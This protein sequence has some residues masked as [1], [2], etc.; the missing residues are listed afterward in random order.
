MV[1]NK[2]N[3]FLNEINTLWE[4]DLKN[5]KI[6]LEN[7][8]TAQL[9]A[10]FLREILK[11]K[12]RSEEITKKLNEEQHYESRKTDSDKF[13]IDNLEI[14]LENQDYVIYSRT[15]EKGD[16]DI[17]QCSNSIVYLLGHIKQELIGKN[18]KYGVSMYKGEL[19]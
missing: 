10:Y 14:I 4:T 3:K 9:Y 1:G 17:I 12:K 16:C 7:Q 6:D 15:N 11:N 5:K 19:L 13:D 8:S 18:I 2:L